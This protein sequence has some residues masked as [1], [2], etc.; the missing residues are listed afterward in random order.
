MQART[1]EPFISSVPGCFAPMQL[2]AAR[3]PMTGSAATMSRCKDVCAA[4]SATTA[5][6]PFVVVCGKCLRQFHCKCVGIKDEDHDL[7]VGTFKCFSCT[8][9]HDPES[10]AVLGGA[11]PPSAAR[12]PQPPTE[13]LPTTTTTTGDSDLL[14]AV[15]LL[16]RKVD[17]VAADVRSLKEDNVSLLERLL[18]TND[19]SGLLAAQSKQ[20]LFCQKTDVAAAEMCP[21]DSGNE[22]L[23]CPFAR[24]DAEGSLLPAPSSGKGVVC[25]GQRDCEL[26]QQVALLRRDVDALTS[27][28][29]LL[30]AESEIFRLHLVR[31]TEV[32]GKIA[33]GLEEKRDPPLPCAETAA[34]A[35]GNAKSYAAALRGD[36]DHCV[37]GPVTERPS[38]TKDLEAKRGV[39]A[40][41]HELQ[42]RRDPPALRR[43]LPSRHSSTSSVSKTSSILGKPR[44]LPTTARRGRKLQSSVGTC[45]NNELLCAAPRRSVRRALFLTRLHP[46]T[47]S[48]SVA[49]FVNGVTGGGNTCV[50]TKLPSKHDTYASFHV[51]VDARDFDGL[52]KAELWPAGCLFRP[53]Y[54]VIKEARSSYG[55]ENAVTD[56][57]A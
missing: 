53:F 28:V 8:R 1:A 41:S 52:L 54:G 15:R 37:V 56:N 26:R 14:Q 24:K 32:L 6:Q 33:L 48:K 23:C 22:V 9:R 12:R 34:A 38:S 39:A 19:D 4:C 17:S 27:D 3:A 49:D 42:S 7:V 30:N 10:A 57:S 47:T 51:D 21:L 2:C 5:R 40:S 31:T 20:A 16:C 36:T 29:R 13:V 18:E 11:G 50:C 45:P 44:G 55:S 25:L 46:S 35:A 43:V